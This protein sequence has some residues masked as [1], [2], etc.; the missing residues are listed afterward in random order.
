MSAPTPTGVAH[1]TVLTSPQGSA[2]T[3]H[4]GTPA[5]SAALDLTLRYTATSMSRSL[6]LLY[7]NAHGTHASSLALLDA[8]LTMAKVITGCLTLLSTQEFPT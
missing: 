8:F 7:E 2:L 1:A 6:L 5:P 4:L 3:W